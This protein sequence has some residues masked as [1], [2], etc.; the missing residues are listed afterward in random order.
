MKLLPILTV[1]VLLLPMLPPTD[2]AAEF[3]ETII[4]Q[5]DRSM[6]E[7]YLSR[8]RCTATA[9]TP[10]LSGLML[11]PSRVHQEPMTTGPALR[12]CWPTP[13]C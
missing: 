2:T 4:D 11:M 3:T 13:R 12:P 6:L 1:C 9:I 7:Y 8:Q 10:L 5:I